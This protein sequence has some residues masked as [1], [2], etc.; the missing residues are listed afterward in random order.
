MIQDIQPHIY[1]NEYKP[2]RPV[3]SDIVFVF[4]GDQILMRCTS[5]QVTFPTVREAG[6]QIHRPVQGHLDQQC[7]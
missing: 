4:R 7:S 1:H 5:E 2:R 3:E 6:Q